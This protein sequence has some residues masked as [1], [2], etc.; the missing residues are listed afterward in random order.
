[1]Q[2]EIVF[3]SGKFGAG[4]LWDMVKSPASP[5]LVCAWSLSLQ[6]AVDLFTA[7]LGES[8]CYPISDMSQVEI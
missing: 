8:K 1:M 6:K 5:D 7:C 2:V 3:P 4:A